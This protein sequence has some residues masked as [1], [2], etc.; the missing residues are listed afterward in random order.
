MTVLCPCDVLTVFKLF[1][2][3]IVLKRPASEAESLFNKI[4]ELCA[5]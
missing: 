2:F 3:T 1:D 4:T 5:S